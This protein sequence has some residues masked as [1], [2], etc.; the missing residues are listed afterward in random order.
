MYFQWSPVAGNGRSAV[1][2][3]KR[4][5]TNTAENVAAA[6]SDESEQTNRTLQLCK[7]RRNPPQTKKSM[8][9][10]APQKFL[11]II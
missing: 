5:A 2:L 8:P 3:T 7:S 11:V 1:S 6:V 9:E 4:Y 10:R